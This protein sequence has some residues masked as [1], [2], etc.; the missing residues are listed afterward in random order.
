[1]ALQTGLRHGERLGG[2][3]GLSGYLP[4]AA[5]LAA[6]RSGANRDVP[7]FLAHGRQDPM[8]TFDRATATRAALAAL[9]HLVDWH[10]YPMP[11]SV[12]AE[13]IADLERWLLRVL[14]RPAG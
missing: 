8:V 12:C 14:A 10:E 3:V 2:I 6:E 9:G 5:T 4:L 7:I 11:H 1:M 13:E